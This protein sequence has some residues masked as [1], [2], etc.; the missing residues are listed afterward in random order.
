[1][2]TYEDIENLV[3]ILENKGFDFDDLD[4]IY[5]TDDRDQFARE[6]LERLSSVIDQRII[7]VEIQKGAF[8]SKP[9]YRK[10]LKKLYTKQ[11]LIQG[12]LDDF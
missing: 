8:G 10:K 11:E 4:D 3:A 7:D 2:K 5:M 9:S 6:I 1:M 12:L